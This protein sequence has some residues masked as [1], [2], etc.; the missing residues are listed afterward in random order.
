MIPVTS[1]HYYLFLLACG[2][3]ALVPLLPVRVDDER[4]R[5]HFP[6]WP[7]HWQGR[8]L[9]RLS[10][11][12]R[13]ASFAANFPGRIARFSDGHSEYIWRWVTRAT[14]KL[15]PADH[16]FQAVGYAI[17]YRPLVVGPN[18]ERWRA[19]V[20][21]RQGERLYVREQIRDTGSQRWTDVSAWYW[22]AFFRR[23]P[24]PWWAITICEKKEQRQSHNYEVFI[25]KYVSTAKNY[26]KKGMYKNCLSFYIRS[27]KNSPKS[28]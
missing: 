28:S 23:S 17:D 16:C 21:R 15:H 4:S 27:F 13:E 19:F 8:R 7:T 26:A 14:R 3:A 1:R 22:H 9:C 18:G 25:N 10:L 12:K 24:G 6:G 20:A 5:G 11:S 2:L